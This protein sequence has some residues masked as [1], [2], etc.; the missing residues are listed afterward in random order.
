MNKNEYVYEY[1]KK[2]ILSKTSPHFA[3][4]LKGE[5]GCGKTFFVKKLIGDSALKLEKKD[6]VYVSL[7]GLNSLEQIDGKVFEAMHPILSSPKMKFAGSLLKSAIKLGTNINFD[8]S[9]DGSHK[10]SLKIDFGDPSLKGVEKIPA[11]RKLLIVDD[12][13]R[14]GKNLEI[15]DVFGYFQDVIS[16][17]DTKVIFIGNENKIDGSNSISEIDDPK[18]DIDLIF[19]QSDEEQKNSDKQDFSY[20]KIKEKSIGQEFLIKPCVNE[21]VEFFVEELKMKSPLK[22]IVSAKALDVMGYLKCENLRCVRSAI[23]SLCECSDFITKD[24]RQS[25]YESFISTYLLL[26]IQKGINAIGRNGIIGALE[27]FDAYKKGYKKGYESFEKLNVPLIKKWPEIIFDGLCSRVDLNAQYCI[28]KRELESRGKKKKLF[29]LLENWRDLN[30]A[31]FKANVD[32]VRKDFVEGKYLHPGKILHYANIMLLFS[33]WKIRSETFASIL[34]DVKD[35]YDSQN[36][37]SVSDFDSLRIGFAGWSY[38]NDLP[39]LR[40]IIEF[41]REKNNELKAKELKS[42][43]LNSINFLTNENIN[44]F[45]RDLWRCEGSNKY[46]NFPFFKFVDVGEV[47]RK[48]DNLKASSLDLFISSL[49][50][51][52]GLKYNSPA[53]ESAKEDVKNLGKIKTTYM[54]GKSS[55]LNSPKNFL[56]QNFARR[57]DNIIAHIK[58]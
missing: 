8:A 38:S 15:K 3:I 40:E 43:V 51:R 50:E 23:W 35:L 18:D 47:C 5:W 39:K 31:E 48:L 12:I 45:C 20:K 57:L 37:T 26:S 28:E 33:S 44:T 49:E 10:S 58:K 17:S 25:D 14:L 54:K 36:V 24:L 1:C 21:A 46:W 2:F 53:D 32:E 19:N 41:V 34:K 4:L 22:E 56:S 27:K 7:F 13:E 16:E 30:D 6:Y 11:M 55:I 9:D 42:E 52:Y 29:V